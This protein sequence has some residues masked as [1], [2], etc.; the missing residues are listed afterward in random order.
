MQPPGL[1]VTENER[2]VSICWA[3][4]LTG[5]KLDAT[6]ANIIQHS[7][8]WCTNERNMLCPTCCVRLH[9]PLNRNCSASEGK[10]SQKIAKQRET[11]KVK[12][13]SESEHHRQERRAGKRQ[14]YKARLATDESTVQNSNFM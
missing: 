1:S 5:F 9:G 6:D 3:K 2:N 12:R 10:R 11:Y 13:A 14:T 8:T 7:P 4:S